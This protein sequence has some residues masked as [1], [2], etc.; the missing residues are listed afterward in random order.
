MDTTAS[1]FQAENNLERFFLEWQ[2]YNLE[3]L[4]IK[5]NI[6]IGITDLFNSTF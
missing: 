3:R 1:S 4:K 5:Y 2:I 6:F